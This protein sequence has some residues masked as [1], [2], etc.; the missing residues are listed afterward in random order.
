MIEGR[1][2][3]NV[4]VNIYNRWG[5]KIYWNT[6]DFTFAQPDN[7]GNNSYGN[8]KCDNTTHSDVIGGGEGA[9]IYHYFI[10]DGIDKRD[11]EKAAEGA[12]FYVI[13]YNLRNNPNT[14]TQ[15]KKGSITILR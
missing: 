2:L 11:G 13:K 9:T 8:A 1:C 14:S 5:V 6:Y 15:I 4:D 10:W 12:Y 3:A 7:N